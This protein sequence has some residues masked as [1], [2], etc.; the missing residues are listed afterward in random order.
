MQ[1]ALLNKA[2]LDSDVKEIRKHGP[3]PQNVDIYMMYHICVCVCIVCVCV[4]VCVC[5][6]MRDKE[7]EGQ[8]EGE[9]VL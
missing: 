3:C 2:V 6:F 7:G 8:G 4:C 1:R 9:T 5:V